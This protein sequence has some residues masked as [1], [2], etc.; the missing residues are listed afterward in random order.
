MVATFLEYLGASLFLLIIVAL[1]LIPPRFD[2]A[3]RM[4]GWFDKKK[5]K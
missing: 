1:V 5:D 2:P 3:I 4:K